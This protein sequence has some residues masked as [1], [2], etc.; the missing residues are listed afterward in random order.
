L[1]IQKEIY[2]QFND[3]EIIYSFTLKNKRGVEVKILNFGGIITS[4]KTPDKSGHIENI[5]LG[6]NSLQHYI[7][8]NS[9]LGA[10]IGRYGNRIANGK[11]ILEGVLY[12][13]AKN[14]PPNHLH[15]GHMGFNKRI[16]EATSKINKDS[17]TLTLN[18]V[19]KDMEEGFPGNLYTTISY[20]LTSENSLEIVYKAKTDKKTIIN[21]TNHAYFN[22]SGSFSN[23]ILDHQL[24]INATKMLPI[25][26][27][28]IPTGDMA[29]VENTPFDFRTFK[30]IGKDI[31]VDNKQL[32]LGLG[33]DHCWCLNNPN[34]GVR[35]IASAYHKKS[36]R[37]LEVFSDQPGVQFYT[38][39]HLNGKHQFRTGFCLETQHYPDSPN[40]KNFPSVELKPNEIYTSN[41]SYKFS[42]H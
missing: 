11:F 42:T 19:S 36:G 41:T 35:K 8:D 33:Y 9:Y 27:F 22:L 7:D 4:I 21:L 30:P 10:I 16:W 6:H 15:G 2:A 25:D 18:Y 23:D 20:S 13:L 1:T 40:H 3:D 31:D 37:L 17:V 14:N 28:L 39:N 12:T 5:T 38:G 29:L 34:K 26:E 24:Q 32:N